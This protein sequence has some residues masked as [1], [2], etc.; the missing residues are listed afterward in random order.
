M[1]L[2]IRQSRTPLSTDRR[3]PR[4]SQSPKYCPKCFIKKNYINFIFFLNVLI[5]HVFVEN[6][7]K[8]LMRLGT[9][10]PSVQKRGNFIYHGRRQGGARG[11]RGP[12]LDFKNPALF[13]QLMGEFFF[14]LKIARF[15][16]SI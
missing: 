8:A 7:I 9:L 6:Q 15:F 4:A 1:Y 13:L 14:L 5:K 11:G 3:S 16:F 12:P 2:H 10:G